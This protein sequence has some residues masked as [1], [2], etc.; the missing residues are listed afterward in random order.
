MRLPREVLAP[1]PSESHAVD[2]TGGSLDSEIVEKLRHL[3]CHRHVTEGGL[4]HGSQRALSTS[5]TPADAPGTSKSLARYE[6]SLEIHCTSSGVPLVMHADA[7]NTEAEYECTATECL[8]TAE[9]VR[10][11]SSRDGQVERTV[12][13]VSTAADNLLKAV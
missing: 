4:T 1:S 12:R 2:N 3:Q 8:S 10:L 11:H 7:G 5:A 6:S 9:Q 13:H